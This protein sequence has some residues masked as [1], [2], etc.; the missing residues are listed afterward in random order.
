MQLFVYESNQCGG[1]YEFTTVTFYAIP[2]LDLGPDTILCGQSSYELK[3]T[4]KPATTVWFDG[5]SDTS[6]TI[7]QPG[8]YFCKVSN[9]CKVLYDTVTIDFQNVPEVELGN[10]TL[11]CGGEFV[12]WYVYNYG[13]TY[14][15]NNG[16]N[17]AWNASYLPGKYW[18]TVENACGLVSDTINIQMRFIYV[19]IPVSDTSICVNDYYPVNVAVDSTTSYLWSDGNTNSYRNL[20]KPGYYIVTVSNECGVVHD[21]INISMFDCNYCAKFPSGFTPNQDGKN[22]IFRVRTDCDIRN[23]KLNIFNRSG[24]LI[25]TSDNKDN[26][27]DGTYNGIEQPIG[28][29]VFQVTYTF[30]DGDSLVE[31]Y[32]SGNV[33]LIR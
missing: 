17:S 24:N 22:D 25:Y 1:M 19:N 13:A 29:Y 30:W 9:L 7:T 14:N 31:A 32:G 28:T 27:W 5:S 3:A 11:I 4:F 18:V 16:S 15:W 2:Y 10:D 23:F 21:T 8:T 26:G 33:T 20:D 6:K 12:S